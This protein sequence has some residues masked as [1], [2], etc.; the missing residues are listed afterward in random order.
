LNPTCYQPG[1]SQTQI[2]YQKIIFI[3]EMP[4]RT[5]AACNSIKNLGGKASPPPSHPSDPSEHPQATLETPG[6]SGGEEYIGYVSDGEPWG[7]DD[8]LEL[9]NQDI[10]QEEAKTIIAPCQGSSKA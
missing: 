8:I 10:S 7:V 4:K 2:K 5:L 3:Y 6:D 9:T 1:T